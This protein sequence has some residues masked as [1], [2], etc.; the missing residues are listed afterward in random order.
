LKKTSDSCRVDETYLKVKDKWTYLYRAVDQNGSTI[1]FWLSR[2]S[3]KKAAKKFFRKALRSPHD[4]NPRVITTD[5]Y[6]A[7]IT[8]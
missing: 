8:H 3:D 2:K 4:S 7:T 6:A 1:D 5:K